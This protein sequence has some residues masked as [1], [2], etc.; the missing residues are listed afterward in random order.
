MPTPREVVEAAIL[1]ALL[2]GPLFVYLWRMQ[3]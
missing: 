3:A 2:T 1:A